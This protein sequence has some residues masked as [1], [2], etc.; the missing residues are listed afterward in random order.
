[1]DFE[2]KGMLGVL[3]NTVFWEIG[4]EE[5]EAFELRELIF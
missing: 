3:K 4:L 2:V 5:D 1:M